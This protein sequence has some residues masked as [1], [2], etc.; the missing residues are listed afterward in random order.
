MNMTWSAKGYAFIQGKAAAIACGLLLGAG[1]A[2]AGAPDAP[3][4]LRITNV[5]VAPRD[6]KTATLH[7]DIAWDG[8]WR[9]E[10]NH[11]AAWVFFKVRA[12]GATEWQ[13]V[14]LAADKV[15][16][17]PL[18]R[19]GSGPRPRLVGRQQTRPLSAV[20]FEKGEKNSQ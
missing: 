6:A 3:S 4:T 11:D 14:R 5:T 9:H 15:L 13:H 12:E 17:A 20:H 1:P 18:A 8:S 7:F 2:H 19:V 10:A 16:K